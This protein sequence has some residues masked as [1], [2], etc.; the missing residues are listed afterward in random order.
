MHF[1]ADMGI[2]AVGTAAGAAVSDYTA[3]VTAGAAAFYLACKGVV[4][5][6]REIRKKQR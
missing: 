2:A 5:V 1:L 3:L 4:L 6:I